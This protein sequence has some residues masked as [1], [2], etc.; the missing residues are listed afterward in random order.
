MRKARDTRGRGAGGS[1]TA[2][3][4]QTAGRLAAAVAGTGNRPAAANGKARVADAIQAPSL[5]DGPFLDAPNGATDDLKAITGIGPKLE[6]TLNSLGVFHYWQIAQ[7]SEEDIAEV[8]ERLSFKGRIERD[9]W[10]QQAKK[11]TE[12]SEA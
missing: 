4:A 3:I 7:W 1:L 12:G 2:S 9:D 6:Q 11:L 8:D 10:V 5:I